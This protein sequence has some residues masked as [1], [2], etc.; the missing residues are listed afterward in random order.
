MQNIEILDVFEIL[1][2][3]KMLKCPKDPFVRSVL[4]YLMTCM[5]CEEI[6]LNFNL[7]HAF[8]YGIN[9]KKSFV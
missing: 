8:K 9:G 5:N 2:T 4:K 3:L 1:I 6:L 7:S